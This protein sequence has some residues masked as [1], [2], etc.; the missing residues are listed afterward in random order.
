M[1]ILRL[2]ALCCLLAVAFPIGTAQAQFVPTRT[3]IRL[4]EQATNAVIAPERRLYSTRF[5]AGRSRLIGAE[6]ALSHPPATASFSFPLDC[7]LVAP[8]GQ[9]SYSVRLSVQVVTGAEESRALTSWSRDNDA[10]WVPGRYLVRCSDRGNVLGE[11]AFEMN[12]NPPDATEVD[13]HVTRIRLFPSGGALPAKNERDYLTRFAAR[14][15]SRIGVEL[16]FA[17]SQAGGTIAIPVDCYYYTPRGQPMG[18]ISF[19]YEPEAGATSGNA[20]LAMGWDSP[21]RWSQG[22]YT[23]VCNI[24]GRPVAVERFA[25]D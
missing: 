21:G 1:E 2:R 18:P 13:L 12:L 10:A 23:A 19:T 5:D 16:E 20:A 3:E 25:I 7:E 8:E 11:A 15:T 14:K 4:W 9:R 24:R 6:I 17:H 22:Q